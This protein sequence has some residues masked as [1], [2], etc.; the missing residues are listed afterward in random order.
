ME[1]HSTRIRENLQRLK[2]YGIDTMA[3]I[4]HFE[5]NPTY[6]PFTKPLF[7]LIEAGEARGVTS[8]LSLMEL[9]VKPKQ[10]GDLAAVEDYKYALTNFPNLKVRSL[11]LE[12]AEKA[13]EIRARYPLRPPDA[14][15]IGTSL[16]EQAE[17][18]I[19]N[20]SRLKT[21]SEIEIIIMKE[22]IKK[23]NDH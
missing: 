12:V 16:V 9:L 5:E 4:Y 23:E 7:E 10:M 19:T 14:I 21:I 17:A 1:D 22:F 20:D 15:Q 3:F 6:T 11:D 8:T 13:A 18:F 2:A